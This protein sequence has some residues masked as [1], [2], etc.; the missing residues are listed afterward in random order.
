MYLAAV[1]CIGTGNDHLWLQLNKS[2]QMPAFQ[3]NPERRLKVLKFK[4]DITCDVG[5]EHDKA[6]LVKWRLIRLRHISGRLATQMIPIESQV[7]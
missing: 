2:C 1:E 6:T 7:H 3:V 5:K 4:F